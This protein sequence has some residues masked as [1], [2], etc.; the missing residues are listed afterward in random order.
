MQILPFNNSL[1]HE[2]RFFGQILIVL[3]IEPI[4]KENILNFFWTL[5]LS[6]AG[7]LFVLGGT[8]FFLRK[9]VLLPLQSIQS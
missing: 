6:F 7:V 4:H 8:I 5:G 1:F 2:K 9:R 3:D